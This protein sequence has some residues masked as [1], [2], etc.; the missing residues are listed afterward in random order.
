MRPYSLSQD[1]LRGFVQVVEHTQ[2]PS[3]AILPYAIFTDVLGFSPKY[4]T[5]NEKGVTEVLTIGG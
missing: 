1:Y 2:H 4:L 5:I 3:I